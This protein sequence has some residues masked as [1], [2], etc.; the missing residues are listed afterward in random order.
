MQDKIY[1]GDELGEQ[2]PQ[3][4]NEGFAQGGEVSKPRL[5]CDQLINVINGALQQTQQNGCVFEI[6]DVLGAL[7]VIQIQCEEQILIP[8]RHNLDAI[9]AKDKLGKYAPQNQPQD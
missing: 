8:Y 5:S 6:S 4:E 9:M 3:D 1:G 7:R 2:V